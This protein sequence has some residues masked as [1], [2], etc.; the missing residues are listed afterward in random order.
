MVAGAVAAVA[1][2]GRDLVRGARKQ[3]GLEKS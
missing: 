1:D 2:M 3:A